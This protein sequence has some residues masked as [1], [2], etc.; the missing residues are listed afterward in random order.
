M[1][2]NEVSRDRDNEKND[3]LTIHPRVNRGGCWCS[4]VLMFICALI[5]CPRVHMSC[6]FKLGRYGQYVTYVVMVDIQNIFIIEIVLL[7]ATPLWHI[8]M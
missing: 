1:Y 2:I 5:H 4:F 6:S 7:V 8:S 3:I